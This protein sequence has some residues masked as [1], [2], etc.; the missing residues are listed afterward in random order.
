VHWGQPT[1]AAVRPAAPRAFASAN[2]ASLHSLISFCDGPLEETRLN[3]TLGYPV[4]AASDGQRYLQTHPVLGRVVG[5]RL[6]QVV[7]AGTERLWIHLSNDHPLASRTEF[8]AAVL[9][10]PIELPVDAW[11]AGLDLGAYQGGLSVTDLPEGGLVARVQLKP[12]S[13]FTM[14]IGLLRPSAAPSTLYLL[15][16][17]LEASVSYGWC[18][19]HLLGLAFDSSAQPLP[20]AKGRD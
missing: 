18:R 4:I 13:A 7:P 10:E 16:R 15:A 20:M 3:A 11:L 8:I 1:V 5:A 19:W 9:P 12:A 14:D 2:L 17:A 6:P